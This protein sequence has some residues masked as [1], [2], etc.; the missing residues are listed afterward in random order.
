MHYVDAAGNPTGAAD[1]FTSPLRL[2]NELYG[3][4]HAN[5]FGPLSLG[6]AASDGRAQLDA[7]KS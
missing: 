3:D 4:R 7:G 1:N 5:K 6:A 2:L